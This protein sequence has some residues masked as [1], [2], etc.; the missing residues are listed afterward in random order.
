MPR[1]NEGEK[2]RENRSFSAFSW[3]SVPQEKK[4]RLA[5]CRKLETP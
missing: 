5:V 4:A 3:V 2:S 1:E